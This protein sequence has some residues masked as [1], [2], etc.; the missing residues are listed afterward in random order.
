MA[1][2]PLSLPPPPPPRCD[3][4]LSEL[5]AALRERL[6]LPP[7]V[8]AQ[9]K[10]IAD[11]VAQSPAMVNVDAEGWF[12]WI[13]CGLPLFANAELPA[14]RTANDQVR[15]LLAVLAMARNHGNFTH[16][17]DKLQTSRRLIRDSLDDAGLYP[18]PGMPQSR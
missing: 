13:L 2:R 4:S 5:T 11:L 8:P 14:L 17:A 1:R 12:A 10:A 16:A 9:A 6:P 7:N 15:L 3:V 18:W